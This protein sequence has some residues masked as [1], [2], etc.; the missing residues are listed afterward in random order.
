MDSAKASGGTGASVSQERLVQDLIA[1]QATPAAKF[2]DVAPS[3]SPARSAGAAAKEEPP[4]RIERRPCWIWQWQG[5]AAMLYDHIYSQLFVACLIVG[6]FLT[7]IV[8]TQIDPAAEHY[9]EVWSGMDLFF[10][11]IFLLELLLNMYGGWLWGFWSS[12]WNIFD[13]LVVTIGVL[14]TVKLELG[15]LRLLRMM[16]AFRVF[17]LFKKIESL[18]KIIMSLVHA[19]PGMFNA[20][21]INTMFMCIFAVLA[22]DFFRDVGENCEED[23][24]QMA[25][26]VTSRENCFGMEYFGN[27]SK[28]LYTLF[29]V[30]TGDSWSE[31]VVRPILLFYSNRGSAIAALASGVF[32]V[33]FIL[34][35]AIILINVVIAVLLDKIVSLQEDPEEK[36]AA[37]QANAEAA[38]SSCS[39]AEPNVMIT[40]MKS[41]DEA[42][43]ATDVLAEVQGLREELAEFTA[44]ALEEARGTRSSI[45]AALKQVNE[46]L[47]VL[48]GT[49]VES[50]LPCSGKPEDVDARSLT[51]AHL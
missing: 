51:I 44:T 49:P 25:I 9:S 8:A 28:S 42:P 47:A 7:I 33:M 20:F 48:N 13:F 46:I 12:G 36:A 30:L 40:V 32:F 29:Q 39:T 34:I 19:V 21:V 4:E 15:P 38:S 2:A 6:N 11:V 1:A 10:N 41:V 27:F 24:T 23:V 14:D 22:V 31:A 18:R 45:A 16:R 35:N 26:T 5:Q 3:A 43:K 50:S 17:R 37:A